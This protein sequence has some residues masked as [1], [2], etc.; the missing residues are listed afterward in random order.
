MRP[1]VKRSVTPPQDAHLFVI[2]LRADEI[3]PIGQEKA[4]AALEGPLGGIESLHVFRNPDKE[5]NRNYP[6]YAQIGKDATCSTDERGQQQVKV[7][8]PQRE[9]TPI[10]KQ[11]KP[12]L[13]R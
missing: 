6:F 10:H 2:G 8:L 4:T 3:I 13:A 1:V 7:L 9:I 12:I 5:T 11:P